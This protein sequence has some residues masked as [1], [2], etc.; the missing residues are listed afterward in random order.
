MI[1]KLLLELDGIHKAFAGK[2]VL[3][4][5]SLRLQQG[6]ITTLI[7]P[8]GAGKSTLDKI[9]LGLIQPD[10]GSRVASSTIRIG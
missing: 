3:E 1:S 9:I 5:V 6:E 7:G 4:N 8:N 2:P 10:S